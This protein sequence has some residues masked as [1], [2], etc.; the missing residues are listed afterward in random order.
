MTNSRYALG[1]I[2]A[3]Q[4]L[5]DYWQ[6]KPLLIKQALPEFINPLSPE[7]IAGLACEEFAESRLITEIDSETGHAPKWQLQHGPFNDEDFLAL[8]DSSWLG[9]GHARGC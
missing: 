4:F 8:P 3:E 2:T 9:S 1:S 5:S 7:E 6:K